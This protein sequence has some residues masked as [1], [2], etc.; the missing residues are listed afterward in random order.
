MSMFTGIMFHTAP[1][2]VCV[3]RRRS[4][5]RVR[6][7]PLLSLSGMPSSRWHHATYDRPRASLRLRAGTSRVQH[8]VVNG[9]NWP[10]QCSHSA[11]CQGRRRAVGA[12]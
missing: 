2:V 7:H 1:T 5:V 8:E 4:W 9:L 12:G 3:T 11:S 6:A 10:S